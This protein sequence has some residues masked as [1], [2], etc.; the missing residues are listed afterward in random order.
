MLRFIANR[1]WA[2]VLTL[3]LSVTAFLLFNAP[4]P[5][6]AY[7]DSGNSQLLPSD[8]PG[9]GYGDPDVPVVPGQGK[10]GKQGIG[11]GGAV[12]AP[13]QYGVRPAGDVTTP[14]S[15]VLMRLRLFLLSWR[16]FYLRF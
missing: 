13:S 7:A 2:L 12:R 9:A 1:W 8:P 16:S 5:P 6:A 15:V 10:A 4:S 3:C 14:T 11:C